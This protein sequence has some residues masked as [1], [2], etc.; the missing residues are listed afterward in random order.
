MRFQ[1]TIQHVP[2]KSLYTADTLSRAPLK[3]PCD[4]AIVN[5]EETEQFVRAIRA[6]LPASADRLETFAKHQ[7]NDNIC[8][9]LIKFCTSG[10]PSRNQLS[11]ELKEYWRYRGCLTLS[12]NLLLYQTRIVVPPEMRQEILIK[13]HHGH[14]GIQRCKSRVVSSVWWPGVSSAMEQFIQSCPICQKLTT[15]PKEPLISTTLPNYPWEHVAAD[16][17][18]LRGANYLLVADYYSRFVEVQKLTT[19]TSSNI[20]T[21]LKAIF[22]RF[23]IPD[24]M[25]TD[26]GPQFDS[27]EMKEFAQSYE[28]QHTTTSPYFPQ[29]NGFAERMVKTMKKL[30][31]HSADPYKSILSYRATPLPWC[32][33]SPAELLMG[34]RIRTDIPQV[35]DNFIP[36][37]EHIQNFKELDEKYKQSQKDNYDTRHRVK[38]LPML[39][40]N[41]AVWVDT[42]GH[43]VPGQI[44]QTAGTPRSYLVE[45]PHGELRRNRAH[46]RIRTDTQIPENA[47]STETVLP[48]PVTI[49]T[50][51][52]TRSQTGTVLRP[53]D[54]LQY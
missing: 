36:K 15:P 10:W 28:F 21:Q 38:T 40:E 4:A 26:N 39:P 30:L 8:S 2:G 51:P 52:V 25:V 9:Q 18:E 46:L 37:W 7:A 17:F 3:N 33:L 5:S 48:Q 54:R 13:I 27:H 42:R 19:T 1:Y 23:G 16:L 32:G 43:Q 29:S 24:I 45:T 50:G 20:I 12:N 34:R 49:R 22:A 31:E 41:Q 11:R 53:P 44:L 35:K 14:Q 47:S 6:V